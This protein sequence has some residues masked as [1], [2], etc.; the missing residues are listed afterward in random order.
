M[1]QELSPSGPGGTY[2]FTLRLAR[3][4]GDLLTRHVG[5]LRS[6]MRYTM[7]HH[8]FRIDEIAVL[9]DVIHT[10]W[11][12]P[13]DTANYPVRLGML[14][15]RFSRFMPAPAYRTPDQIRRG[16]KGIWQRV[17]PFSAAAF[18]SSSLAAG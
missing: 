11:T 5:K 9:P 10:I 2:F 6:A 7:D 15:S 13:T 14:K 17:D 3:R 16:E 1:A 18:I 12:L 4:D 8:G